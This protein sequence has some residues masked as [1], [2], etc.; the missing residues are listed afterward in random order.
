VHILSS[1]MVLELSGHYV[2]AV[3][4]HV[5]AA[6]ALVRPGVDRDDSR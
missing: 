3:Q 6:D 5:N 4:L 2:T 1:L